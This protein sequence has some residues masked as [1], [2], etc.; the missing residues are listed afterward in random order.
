[1][2]KALLVAIT[3][4]LFM[5]NGS[6]QTGNWSAG[7]GLSHVIIRGDLVN[8]GAQKGKAS[9]DWGANIFVDKM[10]NNVFGA[11]LNVQYFTMGGGPQNESK[12]LFYNPY[13]ASDYISDVYFAGHSFG[14][15]LSAIMNLTNLVSKPDGTERKYSLNT[16]FG[17][18]YH[19]YTS[20]LRRIS[21]N[22]ILY[23]FGRNFNGTGSTYFLTGLG[24]K[25]KI[26][27]KIDIELRSTY[28]FNYED[29][30][31]GAISLKQTHEHFITTMVGVIYK[32]KNKEGQKSIWENASSEDE[33]FE[34]VDTDDDGVIDDFDKDN[35]TPKGVK[36]YGDGTAVDTDRDGIADH[37]DSCPLVYGLRSKKGCPEFLD[38]DGDG[39][40]DDKD[41]C[42]DVAGL[43]QYAGCQKEEPKKQVEHKLNL[44]VKNIYFDTDKAEI[45]VE[46]YPTLVELATILNQN[47]ELNFYVDGHTDSTGG[48]EFNQKL[49]ERRANTIKNFLENNLG[50]SKTQ[51]EARGFGDT[52]PVIKNNDAQRRQLNRRVEIKIKGQ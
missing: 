16:Y 11:E 22:N 41:A 15:S 48:D 49:S 8:I 3:T 17:F 23:D 40:S 18:G 38:T 1:M 6:A 20:R 30:L 5:F 37:E 7:G 25:R 14:A 2:K 26:N 45:N 13:G 21:D 33:G 9:F 32:F 19:K 47:P 42:P 24:L 35:R 44:L 50:V 52:V 39:V 28:N 51:L 29:N 46:S 36:V 31:D 12:E 27:D 34:L 43:V 4:V 10:F